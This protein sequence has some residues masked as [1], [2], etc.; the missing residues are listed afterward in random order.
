MEQ[1]TNFFSKIKKI[2]K[3]FFQSKRLDKI[4]RQIIELSV[5]LFSKTRGFYFPK[6]FPWDWKLEMLLGLYEKDTTRLFK[7]IIRPGMTV[8]D[9]GAHIGCY[10]RLSAKLVGPAGRV[11][12]FEPEPENF[13]FLVKNTVNLKNVKLFNLAVS[14]QDGEIA[15]YKVKNSTGCHS[16]VPQQQAETMR[17]R[18]VSLDAFLADQKIERIDII[19]IDIEGGEPLAFKGM[20]NLLRNAGRLGLVTEFSLSALQS[21]NI[22]PEIFLEQ[23]RS[24]GFK[25]FKII[26]NGQTEALIDDAFIKN[27][28]SLINNSIN[29]LAIK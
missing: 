27:D 4:S 21:A 25:L 22:A 19:K 13:Q 5:T 8:V 28:L 12:A 6:K 1:T 14:D 2:Y 20:N 3:R 29:I 18:A 10:T 17:V 7:K 26:T 23:L 16:V 11:L 15:F 9:I 24:Y